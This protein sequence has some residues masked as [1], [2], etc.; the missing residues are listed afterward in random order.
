MGRFLKL[1]AEFGSQEIIGMDLSSAVDP[2]YHNVRHLSN[3]HVVQGDI[4]VPPFKPGFDYI[5]SIGV[6]QF[7]SDP[8]GGFQS[9]VKLL[10]F[11]GQISVWVYSKEGNEAN[12]RGNADNTGGKR[13]GKNTTDKCQ[14]QVQSLEDQLTQKE[15]EVQTSQEQ[16]Q[17]LRTTETALQDKVQS[18]EN[19]LAKKE[20]EALTEQNENQELQKTIVTLEGSRAALIQES[21]DLS[22][23]LQAFKSQIEGLNQ[24]MADREAKLEKM[25]QE[26]QSLFSQINNLEEEREILHRETRELNR[27]LEIFKVQLDAIFQEAVSKE[28]KLRVL[29]K[30]YEDLK[31]RLN[32]QIQ[33][34]EMKISTL[35]DKLNIRLLSKILFAPGQTV[36]SPNGKRV[37]N[38]LA[39]ELKKVEGIQISVEG[40]TDN[41]PLG[42]NIRD[43]Y[44]DNLG[45]SVARSAA[46]ARTLRKMGV[47][48]KILSAAG[49]SMH[50]PVTANTSPDGQ[51]QNRRVEIILA[52]LH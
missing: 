24:K 22:R 45:L 46:V 11:G 9:L 49:F 30:S 8:Q 25:A 23:Q 20:K 41:Q 16:N 29:N 36:I 40:H 3:A 19:Q 13:N 34:K 1:A 4:L 26:R 47:N 35:E 2:A 38:S 18:L 14:R 28:K 10:R 37:L 39:E 7:L 33:E 43:I 12:N 31:M 21:A 52:P 50:R 48:P 44:I 6:L 15:T 32:K 27:Q 17:Q 42:R 5:F 51:Q